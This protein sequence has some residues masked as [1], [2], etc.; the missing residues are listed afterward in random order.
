MCRIKTALRKHAIV[1]LFFIL[2]GKHFKLDEFIIFTKNYYLKKFHIK[3]FS[4]FDSTKKIEI[5]GFDIIFTDQYDFKPF[6]INKFTYFL[7]LS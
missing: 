4:S 1:D 5:R 3:K 2:A 7:E 6:V